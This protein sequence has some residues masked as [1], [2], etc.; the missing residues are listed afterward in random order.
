MMQWSWYPE[1]PLCQDRRRGLSSTLPAP[2]WT[3]NS[4]NQLST[5]S[6]IHQKQHHLKPEGRDIPTELFQPWKQLRLIRLLQAHVF[7][8][9]DDN[10]RKFWMMISHLKFYCRGNNLFSSY[11][12]VWM[13]N[14]ECIYYISIINLDVGGHLFNHSREVLHFII[15]SPVESVKSFCIL[16]ACLHNTKLA[17]G[18]Q[19][20][21]EYQ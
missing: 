12:S 19:V 21:W 14:W 18:I 13:P 8:L 15:K 20:G 9:C 7:H 17:V 1:C 5:S 3:V 2:P 16:C 11:W 10:S 6:I 4:F